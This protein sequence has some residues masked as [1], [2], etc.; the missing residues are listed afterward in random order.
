MLKYLFFITFLVF[1][2]INTT[3]AYNTEWFEN[4]SENIG[5]SSFEC[6]KQCFIVL[7]EKSKND[8]VE[9]NWTLSGSGVFWYWFVNWTEI[10]PWEMFQIKENTDITTKFSFKNLQYYKELRENIV[11]VMIFDWDIKSNNFAAF[12]DKNSFFSNIKLWINDALSYKEYNPRSINFLEWPMWNWR[13]I[14]KVLFPIIIII[15]LISVFW[16]I[17]WEVKIKKWFIYLWIWVLIFF[18]LFFDFLSTLNQ[19]KIYK[20]NIS[21]NNIMVNWRL[22]TTD[23][24]Q[25]LDFIKT[26]VPNKEKWYFIAPY[27][28]DFE[29]KYHI[30]PNIKFD[31]IDKIKYLFWYNPYWINAPFNFKDPTY[32]SWILNYNSWTYQ[33]SKEII[34][35]DYAKIYI[36]K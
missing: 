15:I 11:V 8:F 10:V 19:Y 12:L 32:E 3:L 34:W 26:Q 28:Y 33:V 17:F 18:W 14:N 2:F 1:S 20:K 35:K 30:Y 5:S 27:P 21:S 29:W 31:N 25:Y 23:F 24:Y 22:W 4:Y 36:L 6:K 7:G 9:L 16:Y 13:Y